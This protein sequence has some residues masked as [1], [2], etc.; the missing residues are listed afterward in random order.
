MIAVADHLSAAK[1]TSLH[2]KI[3]SDLHV[4]SL[5]I[6][7][8]MELNLLWCNILNETDRLSIFASRNV[9]NIQRTRVEAHIVGSRTV[10]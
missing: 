7:Y 2:T 4:G 5:I 9:T 8:A 3:I 6:I 10:V 1:P